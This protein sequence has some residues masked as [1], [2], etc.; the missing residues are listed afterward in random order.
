MAESIPSSFPL[1]SLY[2]LLQTHTQ[3]HAHTLWAFRWSKDEIEPMQEGVAEM[4]PE[5]LSLV[6]KGNSLL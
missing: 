2:F 4:K 6:L 5:P 3:T 1:V